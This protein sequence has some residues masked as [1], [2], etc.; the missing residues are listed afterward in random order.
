VAG[1]RD[2]LLLLTGMPPK[3]P[4]TPQRASRSRSG[5]QD[6]ERRELSSLAGN[7]EATSAPMS[8]KASLLVSAAPRTPPSVMRR[9]SERE[10]IPPRMSDGVAS[11]LLPRRRP[12]PLGAA[13]C[14][15]LCF[16]NAQPLRGLRGMWDA[17]QNLGSRPPAWL[18]ET[19]R[20]L[21]HL[22]I[23]ALIFNFTGYVDG[24]ANRPYMYSRV[25]CCGVHGTPAA[26][27]RKY[28]LKDQPCPFNAA[29]TT[30]TIKACQ[31]P[32]YPRSDPRW[33]HSVHCVN[34][35]Y[36]LDNVNYLI[37]VRTPLVS[38]ATAM[39]LPICAAA[40]DSIGR[41]P[42]MMFCFVL[43][44][45]SIL[46]RRLLLLTKPVMQVPPRVWLDPPP[47]PMRARLNS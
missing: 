12:P 41:K 40:A 15:W 29:N 24:D 21:W 42:V 9:G 11:A 5:A 18:P 43:G 47:P 45:L 33:S 44:V 3:R 19:V 20:I 27:D 10:L 8:L 6:A 37:A 46:V 30:C 36:V 26:L 2:A 32:Q 35:A 39:S 25:S 4:S 14:D 31:V 17:Q 34:Y 28:D 7:V 13:L 38:A 1:G 16:P 23:I 22:C